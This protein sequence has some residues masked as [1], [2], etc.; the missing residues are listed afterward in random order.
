MGDLISRL[1]GDGTT[2]WRPDV[3]KEALKESTVRPESLILRYSHENI[4][5]GPQL[6]IYIMLRYQKLGTIFFFFRSVD[7]FKLQYLS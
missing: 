7:F 4:Q 1:Q 6:A 2:L 5:L 3:R